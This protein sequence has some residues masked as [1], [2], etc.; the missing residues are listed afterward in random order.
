MRGG[1]VWMMLASSSILGSVGKGGGK[2]G[3]GSEVWDREAGRDR[4]QVGRTNKMFGCIWM[5]LEQACKFAEDSSIYMHAIVHLTL[6]PRLPETPSP[7]PIPT[8]A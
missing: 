7:S 8:F 6:T 3:E 2:G 1:S 5:R 4:V